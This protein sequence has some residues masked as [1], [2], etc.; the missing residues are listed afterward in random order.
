M[1]S[2]I[3][4]ACPSMFISIFALQDCCLAESD[5]IPEL[6]V[7]RAL[8]TVRFPQDL[9]PWNKRRW[10]KNDGRC[11]PLVTLFWSNILYTSTISKELSVSCAMSNFLRKT[12]WI[13]IDCGACSDVCWEKARCMYTEIPK[14]EFVF[15]LLSRWQQEMYCYVKCHF[16]A[17]QLP[18]QSHFCVGFQGFI[19]CPYWNCMSQVCSKQHF[20]RRDTYINECGHMIGQHLQSSDAQLQYVREMCVVQLVCDNSK[21]S[22]FQREQ[23]C[24]FCFYWNA[25]DQGHQ[26][27]RSCR[28]A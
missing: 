8:R 24:F 3:Y 14:R 9:M 27:L 2:L 7:D 15:E 26:Q 4:E 25:L 10:N 20:D 18:L 11:H 1:C 12:W 21:Q 5:D 16:W 17:R 22:S 19:Q 28:R 23:F 13:H 6:E